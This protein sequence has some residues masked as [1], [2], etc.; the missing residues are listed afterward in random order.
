MPR[1]IVRKIEAKVVQ[2]LKERAGQHGLSMEEA[3]RRIPRQA[4][5]VGAGKRS[6]E[7]AGAGRDSQRH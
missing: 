2:K 4:L 6:P 1:L 5:L 7:R 3:H